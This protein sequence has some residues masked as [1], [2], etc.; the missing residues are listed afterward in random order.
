MEQQLTTEQ[1]EW[2]SK[3]A[4]GGVHSYHL[5]GSVWAELSAGRYVHQ[6]MNN[7]K[8][9]TVLTTAGR[10]ALASAQPAQTTPADEAEHAATDGRESD[11]AIT[12]R[13]NST[14][15]P[16][17]PDHITGKDDYEFALAFQ[18]SDE[19]SRAELIAAL[20]NALDAAYELFDSPDMRNSEEIQTK[21]LSAVT[22]LARCQEK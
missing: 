6:A 9:Y 10:A 1:L 12:A 14:E 5:P 15:L 8:I 7:G 16:Y 2:L 22:I 17:D 19:P 11:T 4:Q 21:M 20:K 18:K 13:L 3:I